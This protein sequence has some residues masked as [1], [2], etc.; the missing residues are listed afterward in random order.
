MKPEFLKGTVLV[1]FWAPWCSP[2]KVFAPTLEKVMKDFSGIKLLKVNV[3]EEAGVAEEL[4]VLGIPCLILLKDGK[5]VARIAGSLSETMLRKKLGE[6][7][8]K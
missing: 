7:V 1:D 2:C 3:D 5:E 6:G 8:S 4:G